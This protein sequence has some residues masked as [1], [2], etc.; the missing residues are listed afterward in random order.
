ME[1]LKVETQCNRC[2]HK[3]VCERYQKEYIYFLEDLAKMPIPKHIKITTN[4][5]YAEYKPVIREF[6]P[7]SKANR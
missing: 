1:L 5:I 7:V 2:I 6:D 3:R 4:C